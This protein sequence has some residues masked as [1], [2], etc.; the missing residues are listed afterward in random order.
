MKGELQ[1][2][3]PSQPLKFMSINVGRGGTTQDIALDRACEL[4]IDVL[5]IQK[6]W[7]SGLT[8][9][10]PFFE[11]HLP[12]GGIGVRPRAVTYTRKNDQEIVSNQIFPSITPTSDYCWVEVNGVMFLNVYKEPHNYSAVRP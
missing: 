4:H 10:H 9:S 11:R 2:R 8:K 1:F 12:F 7:W 5:L 3:R 6:P